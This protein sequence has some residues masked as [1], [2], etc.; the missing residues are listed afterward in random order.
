MSGIFPRKDKEFQI[1]SV[2]NAQRLAGTRGD[3]TTPL[4]AGD[5]VKV[6]NQGDRIEM[7]LGGADFTNP[8]WLVIENT[9]ELTFD[10]TINNG[11]SASEYSI[12]GVTC[13]LG[14][15]TNVGW[16]KVMD[17]IPV[18]DV[19]ASFYVGVG[20]VPA[21]YQIN[22]KF[23]GSSSG[24]VYGASYLTLMSDVIGH[25]NA[26][27]MMTFQSNLPPRASVTIGF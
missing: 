20:M 17:G 8:N 12:N 1:H 23:F 14:T 11:P 7:Y 9:I 22:G 5:V 16:V 13:P 10:L 21:I 26:V 19:D 24:A 15:A 3:D 6:A 4:V 25:L 27:S 2:T 18:G